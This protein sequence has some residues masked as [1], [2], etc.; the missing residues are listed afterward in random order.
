[1]RSSPSGGRGVVDRMAQGRISATLIRMVNAFVTSS[2]L[3]RVTEVMRGVTGGELG[4]GAAGNRE[5]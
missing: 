4:E 5:S 2:S 1:M 3:R